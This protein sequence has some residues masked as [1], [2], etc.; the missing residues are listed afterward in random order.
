VGLTDGSGRPKSGLAP[1]PMIGLVVD[2][3]DPDGKGRI[4]VKFP[5]LHEEAE[6]GWIRMA[7]PMA[8]KERGL[9]ALPEEGDEVLVVFL[10]GDQGTGVII[11]HL[12]NG[13]DIPPAEAKDGLPG[14]SK[15]D[16][17]A[18][19]STDTFT[20]GSKDIENNDRRFWKSR[21]GHLLV[22]DDTDGAESVQIWDKEHTLSFVFDSKEKRI[23][24][25]NTGGDLHIRTKNDLYLEAGNDIKWRSGANI[26]GE[27]AQDTTHEAANWT[28]EATMDASLK[29][30]KSFT[31]EGG[32]D[33][34]CKG[35]INTTV[36]GGATLTAKGGASA[37]LDGG[38]GMAEVKAS[39]VKIN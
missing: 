30:G 11:G 18:S 8:G 10:N 31:I 26:K 35:K 23:L 14:P 24:L 21:S 36:E 28:A 13:Q 15:T 7:T 39:L 29:S 22:F 3:V 32:T 4:K 19:W 2:N 25:A 37:T 16:T 17:G 33:L 9:Y 34:T 38:S 6:S 27:S 12:W 20:D 1:Y 5:M